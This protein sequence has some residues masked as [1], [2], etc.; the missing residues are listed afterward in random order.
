LSQGLNVH[1]TLDLSIIAHTGLKLTIFLLSTGNSG[2][3]QS[4]PTHP[5]TSFQLFKMYSS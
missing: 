1:T 3:C 2:V 5:Y 4:C